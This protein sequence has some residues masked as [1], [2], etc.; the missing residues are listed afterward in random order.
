VENELHQLVTSARR[1]WWLLVLLP[2]IGGVLAFGI[3]SRQ[4]P[5]YSATATLLINPA[6]ATVNDLSAINVGERLAVTYQELV[7]TEP[8]LAPVIE[9]LELPYDIDVLDDKL[10]VSAARDTQLLRIS[11]S[12]TDPEVAALI[13][14]TVADQFATFVSTQTVASA[15]TSRAALQTLIEDSQAQLAATRSRIATLE[16]S[17]PASPAEQGELESLRARAGQ[18]EQSLAGLL[19]QAQEM[20]LSAA[21]AQSRVVPVVPATAPSEPY[22]PRVLFY[23]L[24]ALFIGGLVGVGVVALL[25]YLDNTVNS[26]L[27]YPQAFGVPLLATITRLPKM[28]PGQAQRFVET[29]SR[30]NAAE[31]VRLLRTNLEFAAATREIATLAITSAGTGEGKSTV[32]ANVAMSLAQAGFS[33][34]LIDADLRRPSQ[35]LI[36]NARNERGLTTMLTRPDHPWQWAAIREIKPNLALI[37]SGPLPPNPADLLT[38]DRFRS[39]LGEIRQAVDVVIL[40]TSPLLAV[41]DPLAVATDVDGVVV[42][43]QAGRTR[44]AALRYALRMLTERSVR[45]V[46]VVLNQATGQDAMSYYAYPDRYG[47]DELPVTAE[48][49]AAARRRLSMWNA[50]AD[51]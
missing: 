37:P 10:A 25:E 6:P 16:A 8:V 45:V 4:E 47:L 39:L 17:D 7:A 48:A 35:H 41:S 22:A 38:F 14:N 49:T 5:R 2:L 1:W 46:G 15:S 29:Q 13:A 18:L 3:S 11:V 32:A 24:L 44:R 43:A 30:S 21:A 27:D 28:Q 19:L 23:T 50:Q 26:D 12:D 40:D 36:W 31:S 20:D 51:P 9:Q 33:T 42:V 34:V